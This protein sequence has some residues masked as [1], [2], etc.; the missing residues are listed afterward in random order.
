MATMGV[1]KF[2]VRDMLP[3]MVDDQRFMDKDIL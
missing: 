2:P 3:T 1:E